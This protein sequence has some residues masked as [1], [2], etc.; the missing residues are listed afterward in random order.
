MLCLKHHIYSQFGL[1][2]FML[3]RL[4][5][6]GIFSSPGSLG[7]NLIFCILY[8]TF[9]CCANIDIVLISE[10]YC[11]IHASHHQYRPFTFYFPFW[12]IDVKYEV[13]VFIEL[14]R[15]KCFDI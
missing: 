3:F 2:P 5:S 14:L 10:H 15:N 6:I 11:F 1:L 4:T 9:V 8:M 7:F 12:I 13:I